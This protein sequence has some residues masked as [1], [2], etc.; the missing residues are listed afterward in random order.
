[1]QIW[2][3]VG[4]C[5]IL[6]LTA[7]GMMERG[8]HRRRV[9]QIPLRINV[10]GSRGKSTVTRLLT[11][12]LTEAG[13]RVVGK[14]TGS[15]ARMLYWFCEEERAIRRGPLGANISEQK[16]VVKEAANW[17]AEALVSECMA[18]KPAYQLIFQEEL[19]QAQLLVITNVLAD[20]LDVMGPT[21]DDVA[22]HFA[23]TIPY[24]GIL[25]I[26]PG[27]YAAYFCEVAAERR[28]RVVIADLQRVD[29]ARLT[30]F[31]YLLFAENVALALAVADALQVDRQLAWRGMM[32]AKPDPGALMY[33]KMEG[34]QWPDDVW[35]FNG[36]A[37]NDAQ[38]ARAVWHKI[39]DSGF[40]ATEPLIVLNC[41][42]DR[43]ERTRQF[44]NEVLPHLPAH[45]LLAVGTRTEPIAE[46]IA[47]A[48]DDERAGNRLSVIEY[49]DLEGASV[50]QIWQA[51]QQMVDD[52]CSIVGMGNIH[53]AGMELL[54]RIMPE[55]GRSHGR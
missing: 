32:Q 13:W 41:R 2:P 25:V 22:R 33:R 3:L 8:L 16:M 24:E 45:R 35:F 53:G 23:A 29:E 48:R 18:L 26:A 14:T 40:P 49:R 11:A 21:V 31:P 34:Q 9:N 20:H 28:T 5:V 10:N 30:A 50:E 51:M 19:L 54:R 15:A 17:Q 47:Q 4:L 12:M 46:A 1:M 55:G 39:V 52:G 36:F 6:L 38:S 42:A 7:V 27:P 37:A 44:A 43:V